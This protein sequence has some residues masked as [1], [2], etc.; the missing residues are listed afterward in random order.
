M[1]LKARHMGYRLNQKALY[2]HVMRG[3]KAEKITQGRFK[4]I[5][6]SLQIKGEG[7]IVF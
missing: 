2:K 4:I 6:H 3:A 1:R 7:L 5:F